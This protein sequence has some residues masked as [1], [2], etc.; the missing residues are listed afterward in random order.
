MIC[1]MIDDM[2]RYSWLHNRHEMNKGVNRKFS[3]EVHDFLQKKTQIIDISLATA[4]W[5]ICDIF[6]VL[7]EI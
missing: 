7:D 5:T 2:R 6:D 1:M 3:R 4:K